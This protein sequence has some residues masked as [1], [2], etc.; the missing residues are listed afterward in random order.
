MKKLLSIACVALAPLVYA[1]EP[2][3][4]HQSAY[5]RIMPGEFGYEGAT[6]LVFDP[7][8][9]TGTEAADEFVIFDKDLKQI[10][11]IAFPGAEKIELE[12]WSQSKWGS[13]DWGEVR[14]ER[15]QFTKYPYVGLEGNID[16][17]E[18]EYIYVSQTLFNSDRKFEY[19]VPKY[20]VQQFSYESE[21]E[22]LGGEGL[23]VTGYS[24]MSQDGTK[25]FDIDFPS[26]YSVN[27]QTSGGTGDPGVLVLGDKNP[28]T[29]ISVGVT[30]K[31]SED[32]ILIYS[33]NGQNGI[34][35][36]KIVSGGMNVS[37]RMP[38]H[39]ESVRV[40]L[41]EAATRVDLVNASG[42][43]M[44]SVAV[45]GNSHSVNVPTDGLAPGVYVV[46]AN[47]REAA[48]IIIR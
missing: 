35:S 3:L 12:Q 14:E 28:K 8:L 15:R 18:T 20:S 4:I 25:L 24:V 33:L 45:S 29:Y 23:F 6:A 32:Y 22:R 2:A 21:H 41:G 36:P 27:C 17:I 40:D 13:D 48:K 46:T 47:S 11:S 44:R 43:K 34:S 37:P 30:N 39:G 1:S 5:L 26:G 16:G 19:L 38:R 7:G 10:A 31:D 9:Y 42:A